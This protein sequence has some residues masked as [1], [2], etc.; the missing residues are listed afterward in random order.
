[1]M[2]FTVSLA[3]AA[4]I[5]R[6][7]D[8][9]GTVHFTD[10]VSKIPEQYRDQ[11]K[12]MEVPIEAVKEPLKET[13]RIGVSEESTDRVQ[14]YLEDFDAKVETKRQLEKTVLELEEELKVSEDRV[15]EIEEYE[16]ENYIYFI[17]FR[18]H[19]TGK[20]VPV[21]SP[22]YDEKVKLER[23]IQSI[24]SELEPLYEKLSLLQRSL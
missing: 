7:T 6:W 3:H 22:Y 11:T 21:G 9:K 4:E 16:R 8:E 2:F 13:K 23:R 1:M 15:K 20:F 10:D 17:P 18:D 24:R 14:K 5:Y 12:K 19:Q